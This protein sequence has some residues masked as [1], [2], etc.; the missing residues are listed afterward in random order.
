MPGLWRISVFDLHLVVYWTSAIVTLGHP[1]GSLGDIQQLPPREPLLL[2]LRKATKL[3]IL[4]VSSK[5]TIGVDE[6][7]SN[8]LLTAKQS[9]LV[10]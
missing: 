7:Q 9:R 1:V 2:I 3:G 6:A 10:C 8:R 4:S 5:L